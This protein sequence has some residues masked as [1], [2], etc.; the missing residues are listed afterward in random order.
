MVWL[1]LSWLAVG[2][3][4]AVGF[5]V[6]ARRAETVGDPLASADTSLASQTVDELG[7][8]PAVSGREDR[9]AA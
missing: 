7:S 5:G 2:V 8:D 4:V 9:A 1:L 6:L 3:I